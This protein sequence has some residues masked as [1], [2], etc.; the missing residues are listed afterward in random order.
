M[1]PHSGYNLAKLQKNIF[2][3]KLSAWEAQLIRISDSFKCA[4]KTRKSYF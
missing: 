3:K 4:K 1:L 2:E